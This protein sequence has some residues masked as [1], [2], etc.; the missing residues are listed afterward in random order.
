MT[1]RNL[2]TGLV[3]G[4]GLASQAIAEGS[5]DDAVK[6]S[7]MTI[8]GCVATDKEHSFVLTNVQEVAGPSSSI[9]SPTLQAMGLP[10]STLNAIY[11]LSEDSVKLMRGHVG[12]KVEV[13][14]IITDVSIGTTKITQDPGKP[15]PNNDNKVEVSARGKE[16]TL[17][18]DKSVKPGQA[19]LT[20]TKE[21]RTM[22]VRRVKVDTV[23]MISASCQ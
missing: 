14:G 21:T 4:L 15:G 1:N 9:P 20:K 19:P 7:S 3:L 10:G 12:H 5:K 11:W 18:T 16:S 8:T 6:G 23:K 22:P 17:E 2:V 13:T